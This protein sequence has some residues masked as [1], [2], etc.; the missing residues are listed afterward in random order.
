M[1]VEFFF[2]GQAVGLF[3]DI[4]EFSQAKGRRTYMPYRSLGHLELH[5][6]LATGEVAECTC[7]E[8]SA[9]WR[10]TVQATGEYGVIEVL[11]CYRDG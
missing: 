10:L 9:T 4:H 2:E 11:R 8:N 1:D 6:K 5:E 3:T 7:V